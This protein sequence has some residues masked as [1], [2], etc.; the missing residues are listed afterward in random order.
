MN[1]SISPGLIFMI[2]RYMASSSDKR[3]KFHLRLEGIFMEKIFF[4]VYLKHSR[5]PH[6]EIFPAAPTKVGPSGD[7][8]FS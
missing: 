1:M 3:C 7:T 2:L 8:D 5:Q 6:F 4:R